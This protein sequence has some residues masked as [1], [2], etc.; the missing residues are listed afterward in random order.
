[1]AFDPNKYLEEKTGGGEAFNPDAYLQ[2]KGSPP[3][4][5]DESS[6]TGQPGALE[7]G[8]RGLE[9]G[10]TLGAGPQINGALD[11]LLNR[12]QGL[13]ILDQY[14]QSRDESKRA[15]ANAASAHPYINVAS[16]VIGSVPTIAATGG[17]GMAG[18]GLA[19]AAK[20]G[21]AIGALTG[22]NSSNADITKGDIGG[23]AK[24][25]L[26]GGALGA[27]TGALGYGAAQFAKGLGS[28]VLQGAKNFAGIKPIQA[29]VKPFVQGVEHG[30]LAGESGLAKAQDLA[31]Q[32]AGEST[33][34][35]NSGNVND[36]INNAANDTMKQQS[37]AIGSAPN[38]DHTDYTSK[39]ADIVNKFGNTTEGI[40]GKQDLDKVKDVIFNRLVLDL[41]KVSQYMAEYGIDDVNAAVEQM[42]DEALKKDI[43]P[44]DFNAFK[45]QLGAMG[46]EGENPIKNTKV[47]Q[48]VNRLVSSPDRELNA[49]EQG[50]NIPSDFTPATQTLEN[51][52]P[53]LDD[54]NDRLSSLLK[55]KQMAPKIGTLADSNNAEDSIRLLA[56]TLPSDVAGQVIPALR[57]S[58]ATTGV[59]QDLNAAG[60]SHGFLADT[61]RGVAGTLGNWTGATYKAFADATPESIKNIAN[62]FIGGGTDIGMKLGNILNEAASRDKLGRNALL[63]AIQQNPAYRDM[64]NK[65]SGGPGLEE[66]EIGN[67]KTVAKSQ[68]WGNINGGGSGGY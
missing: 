44:A 61:T 43:S 53:G 65:A 25:A 30:N 15:F 49:V 20:A 63:F 4:P 68:S 8:L 7:A 32:T 10:A 31:L 54:I 45:R 56:K 41:P 37:N 42:G 33:L 17:L 2:A 38:F 3:S 22:L 11:T 14:R 51:N 39:A 12:N 59:A 21:G 67:G 13:G 16:N 1:M 46:T 66:P 18:E 5:K 27:G 9:Q 28:S 50:F 24:D 52:V 60:L 23:A 35:E 36:V 47:L 19:G 64:L 55:A 29:V 57:D 6:S 26:T 34:G 62:S 48:L 58:I 40:L